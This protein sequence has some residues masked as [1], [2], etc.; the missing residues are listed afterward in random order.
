MQGCG[1][2]QRVFLVREGQNTAF[3]KQKFIDGLQR[4]AARR[5]TEFDYGPS[6]ALD[7][8]DV[9]GAPYLVKPFEPGP[10]LLFGLVLLNSLRVR[11]GEGTYFTGLS[12]G[13]LIT[14]HTSRGAIV[15]FLSPRRTLRKM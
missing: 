1:L 2:L 10:C 3:S 8:I 11:E 13:R 5:T 14:C 6:I 7:A 12:L 4:E 15:G 9:N